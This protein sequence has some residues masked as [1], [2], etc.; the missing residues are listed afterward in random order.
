[1]PSL[2]HASA[3][4]AVAV[5]LAIVVA[6]AVVVLAIFVSVSVVVDEA[7]LFALAFPVSTAEPSKTRLPGDR[8]ST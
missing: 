4:A 8:W 3:A 7:P 1:M 2:S 5:V 6:V